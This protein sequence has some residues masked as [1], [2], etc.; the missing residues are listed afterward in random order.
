MPWITVLHNI[1]PENLKALIEYCERAKARDQ[2][3][4]YQQMPDR[5]TIESPTKD[6][7][8]RRGMLLHYKF[9]VFFEVF[10]QEAKP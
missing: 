1:P 6:I 9:H 10:F 3:F 5:I 8:Y 4:T 2:T 7:A